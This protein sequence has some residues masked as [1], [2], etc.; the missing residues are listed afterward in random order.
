MILKLCGSDNN[1]S[2]HVC[3]CV[4]FPPLILLNS[5]SECVP[6]QEQLLSVSVRSPAPLTVLLLELYAVSHSSFIYALTE[7]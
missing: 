5:L 6:P 3:S 7:L 1:I 4:I 2:P